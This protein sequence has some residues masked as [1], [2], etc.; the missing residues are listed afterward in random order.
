MNTMIVKFNNY[1]KWKHIHFL[2]PCKEQ[3]TND[4]TCNICMCIKESKKHIRISLKYYSDGFTYLSASST[5]SGDLELTTQDPLHLTM[6]MI[7]N[8]PIPL[9]EPKLRDIGFK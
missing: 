9:S 3:G 2:I 6:Q 5:F 8:L 4:C 1:N 7:L